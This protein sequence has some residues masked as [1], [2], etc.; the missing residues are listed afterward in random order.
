M[1]AAR[2]RDNVEDGG[3]LK[4]TML[5]NRRRS[6]SVGRIGEQVKLQPFVRVTFISW[7]TWSWIDI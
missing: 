2:S 5:R 1:E 4:R 6:D 7:L 3:A